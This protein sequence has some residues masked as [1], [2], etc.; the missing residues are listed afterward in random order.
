MQ[1]DA[2]WEEGEF[3]V[4]DEKQDL[5]SA[6]GQKDT[7]AFLACL[8]MGAA[9]GVW[10]AAGEQAS[11]YTTGVAPTACPGEGVTVYNRLCAALSL[12]VLITQQ[13]CAML[14]RHRLVLNLA[15][16]FWLC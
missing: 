2:G 5:N 6:R 13:Q 9:R 12:V 7:A 15:G 8:A 4:K 10:P 11:T 1:Q 3:R 14:L 16:K